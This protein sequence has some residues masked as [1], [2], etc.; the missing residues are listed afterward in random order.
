MEQA[1]IWIIVLIVAVTAG[2]IISLALELKKT[3]RS[4]NDFLATTEESVR[5]L[6]PALEEV[7]QTLKSARGITDNLNDVTTDIKTLSGAVR[8]VGLTVRQVSNTVG[9]LASLTAIEASGLKAGFKAGAIY[10][11]RNLFFKKGGNT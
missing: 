1:W 9:D 11:L 5:Q 3:L 6:K 7:Q 4:M 8:D 2:F 10:F